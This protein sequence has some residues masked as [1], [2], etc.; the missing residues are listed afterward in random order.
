MPQKEVPFFLD[1]NIRYRLVKL[2]LKFQMSFGTHMPHALISRDLVE[3]VKKKGKFFHSPYPDFYAMC[4]LFLEAEQILIYPKELV[5]IGISTKSHGYYFFNQKEEE[6]VDFL[7]IHHEL[8]EVKTIRSI[9]LPGSGV[10]TF[11]LAAM[12]TLKNHFSLEKYGLKLEYQKYRQE[13]IRHVLRNF[14][15]KKGKYTTECYQLLKQLSRKE[16]IG[17]FYPVLL[18]FTLKQKVPKTIKHQY[19]RLCSSSKKTVPSTK[20]FAN[21]AEIYEQILPIDCFSSILN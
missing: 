10:A 7:N 3:K 12:E 19:R 15:H 18:W 11:W 8:A 21:A 5:V 17:F 14:L 20:T 2:L 9:L 4:A 1:L 16:K 6:G 13:Q